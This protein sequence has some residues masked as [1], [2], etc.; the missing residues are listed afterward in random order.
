MTLGEALGV[1]MPHCDY[2]IYTESEVLYEGRKPLTEMKDED[3]NRKVREIKPQKELT[4]Y[5]WVEA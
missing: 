1:L 3:L 5:I 4:F 2:S